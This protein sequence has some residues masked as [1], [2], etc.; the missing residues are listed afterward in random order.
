MGYI[1]QTL[2]N[3]DQVL[4]FKVDDR[5]Y[6]RAIANITKHNVIQI[7]E[8]KLGDQ[9]YL[10]KILVSQYEAACALFQ[11]EILSVRS[12]AFYKSIV[13]LH[14]TSLVTYNSIFS[15]TEVTFDSNYD[16]Q[17]FALT[18]RILKLILEVSLLADMV[19]YKESNMPLL[20]KRFEPLMDSIFA[21]G[22]VIFELANFIA[23]LDLY[24]GSVL[25]NIE[26]GALRI[27]R[28]KESED[29]INIIITDITR[30]REKIAVDPGELAGLKELNG[31]LEESMGVSLNTFYRVLQELHHSSGK[32][33][34]TPFDVREFVHQLALLGVDKSK[35][36]AF[37]DGLVLSRRNSQPIAEVPRKPK[38]MVRYF[39]RPILEWKVDGEYYHILTEQKFKESIHQYFIDTIPWGKAPIEWM[40]YP[41][42]KKYVHKKEDEHDKWLENVLEERLTSTRLVYQRN[43][44]R[45][46]FQGGAINLEMNVCGE[47][48]FIVINRLLGVIFIVECKYHQLTAEMVGYKNDW[49][50]FTGNNGYNLK[51]DKKVTWIKENLNSLNWH[52]QKTSKDI[53]VLNYEVKGLFVLS[54]PTFYQYVT[55]VYDIVT[56]HDAIKI[57]LKNE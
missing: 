35:A 31:V 22:S 47:I 45:I 34:T 37:I 28:T 10:K 13:M 20:I 14:D 41:N 49:L 43:V 46:F 15:E 11:N 19:D 2:K 55:P 8:E 1:I 42:F 9:D 36:Q 54:T 32:G 53:E 7:Q 6:D 51:M 18:R 12:L 17:E 38:N 33:Q 30:T 21:L 40:Q 16:E 26:R 23:E 52:F 56:I 50:K 25:P 57:L 44:K 3:G 29:R 24:P 5:N 39:Y 4:L 27:I 48:D